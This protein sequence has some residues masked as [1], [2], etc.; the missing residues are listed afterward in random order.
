MQCGRDRHSDSVGVPQLTLSLF[1]SMQ[2]RCALDEAK[3]EV[4]KE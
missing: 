1:D 3:M 4:K 2:Q